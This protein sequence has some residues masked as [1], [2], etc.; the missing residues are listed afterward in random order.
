[1]ASPTLLALGSYNQSQLAPPNTT[2]CDGTQEAWDLLYR[3]LPGFI[4]T[5]C[6]LGLLG[7]LF[8]LSFFLLPRRRL[9][10]AEIYLA[11]LAA[12]DLVFILGLPF[13]AKNIWDNFHWP[14]G[15]L[16]CRIVN[17][18]IKA[19]LFISIFLVVAISQDRYRALVHPMA[20][21]RLRRRR[22]AQA[23]C[24]LIW[25]L[26]GLLSVPTFLLRTVRPVPDLNISACMLEFPHEAWHYVKIVKLTVLGF[27]LPLAAIV[28]FNYHILASL[29]RSG[30][31]E[32]S[33]TRCGG[34]TSRKTTV[35]ILTLV[36]AFLVCWAPYHFFAFLDF[37][38]QVRAVQGCP[39]EDLVDLGL[40]FANFFAFIN[41][42][43]NP[44]IYVLVGRPF[45]TKA[46]ELYK[47]CTPRSLV[48]SSAHEKEVLQLRWWK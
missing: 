9:K 39:W 37:L 36:V 40:Q 28:F 3:V 46:W 30:Q 25:G 19:N 47:Q 18:V 32:V 24:V 5:I 14:F 4:I 11:N 38:F 26:G 2:F 8:V 42:C 33:R 17:G 21:Q 45:R 7:N 43:L 22:Q 20:S 41:S 23:T 10:V 29:R 16:L 1:M 31:R 44:V 6:V 48:Q 35:L 15:V 34:P 13:W 12:S 27:L